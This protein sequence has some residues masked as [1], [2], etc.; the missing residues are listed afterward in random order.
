MTDA[1]SSP[2]LDL[3]AHGALKRVLDGGHEFAAGMSALLGYCDQRRPHPVWSAVAS[4]DY[5]GDV[6][7]MEAWLRRKLPIRPDVEV[8]WLALWEVLEGFDLRGSSSWS[9]DPED[10]QWWFTDDYSAGSYRSGVLQDMYQAAAGADDPLG[11]RPSLVELVDWVAGAGYVAL[12]AILCIEQ[13]D[14]RVLLGERD[15]LW[16]VLGHPDALYG[17]ILGCVTPA[18]FERHPHGRGR[19]AATS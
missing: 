14:P 17:V 9:R 1:P 11:T 13:I 8:L 16:L 5:D 12:A 19:P 3:H 7:R 10:W 4:L 15:C 2:D 18:G 6:P